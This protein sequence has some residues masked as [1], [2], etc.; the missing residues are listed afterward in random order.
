MQN[1]LDTS[2]TIVEYP[3][4]AVVYVNP[5]IVTDGSAAIFYKSGTIAN[6]Q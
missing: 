1:V 2:H 5:V 6:S 4:G 3:S